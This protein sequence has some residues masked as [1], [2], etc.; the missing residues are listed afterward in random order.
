[1]MQISKYEKT[2]K[3]TRGRRIGNQSLSVAVA[4]FYSFTTDGDAEKRVH[5]NA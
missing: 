2:R 4:V 1:M 3:P 5:E